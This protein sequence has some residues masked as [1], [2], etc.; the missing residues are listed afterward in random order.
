MGRYGPHR[1][2]GTGTTQSRGE[3]GRLPFLCSPCLRLKAMCTWSGVENLREPLDRAGSR[4]KDGRL[5]LYA[6]PDLWSVDVSVAGLTA[7]QRESAFFPRAAW[8]GATSNNVDGSRCCGFMLIPTSKD[9]FSLSFLK[10]THTHTLK[11]TLLF[12]FRTCVNVAMYKQHYPYLFLP[13]S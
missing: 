6:A 7:M 12:C 13:N 5:F 11:S 10:H 8:G 4:E 9:H 2:D 1:H 3:D